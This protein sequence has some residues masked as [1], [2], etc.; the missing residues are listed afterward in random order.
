VVA[1]L[2]KRTNPPPRS[3]E[4]FKRL[5]RICR[6]VFQGLEQRFRETNAINFY[7]ALKLAINNGFDF[8]DIGTRLWRLEDALLQRKKFGR[9]VDYMGNYSVSMFAYPAWEQHSFTGMLN[10][11]RLKVIILHFIS[12]R[13]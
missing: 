2:D 10:F 5:T 7:L 3:E 11:Y 13:L 12:D 6:Q 8:Y 1:P 9:I 4:T